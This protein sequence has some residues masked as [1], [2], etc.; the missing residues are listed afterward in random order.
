[1]Q[2]SKLGVS[3]L[4]VMVAMVA[5]AA[6]A[7][8]TAGT[9]WASLSDCIDATCRIT[10]ADGSC[11]TGCVFEIDQG[12]VYV[13]TAAHVVGND[14][15]VQCEFWRQG[16]QSAPLAGQV[17]SRS[18]EAD[19]AI[20]AVPE[21]ALG[22]L[23]PSVIPLAPRDT[24]IRPG[25]TLTSVGCANGAWSTSWKGHALE[26]E[27]GDL[28]F[29]PTPANGRSGSA[30]FDA[31]GQRIVGVLRARTGD[32]AE[33]IATPIQTIYRAFDVAPQSSKTAVPRSAMY[34]AKA[35]AEPV[36]RDAAA[37]PVA[38]DE[39]AA[40]LDMVPVQCGPGGCCP[41]Q[42]QQQP[43]PWQN[44]LLPYRSRHD[45]PKP[46]S[47]WPSLPPV[48]VKPAVDIS[49]LDEKLGRI[50]AMLEDMKKSDV[51]GAAQRAAATATPGTE[52]P[53]AAVDEPARKAAETALNQVAELR[54]E[55]ERNL[56]D[57]KTDVAKANEA[58][59]GLTTAVERI[60]ESMEE[61]G[62]LSQ[63]FHARVDK[64]KAELEEKLGHE[65]SNHEVRIAYLKDLIQD[66]LG[67]GGAMKMLLI[68][69]VLVLVVW[70]IA[71]DV[72]NK[73]EL[74]TPLAVERLVTLVESKFGALHDRVDALKDRL[75]STTA[76]PAAPA[77]P[78]A[79]PKTGP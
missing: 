48:V 16:H 22:G 33:G 8:G 29:L 47:P 76:A 68:P 55:S 40:R 72:K 46:S 11:G 73:V 39:W 38:R 41:Q 71:R 30:V 12:S 56:H 44:H 31:E 42:Q 21:T 15:A 23:L 7:L 37:E 6:F 52:P 45:T 62:T 27:D 75:Q 69:A 60:K 26:V 28:H 9:C 4:E 1:M 63:R 49:P 61:N 78:A 17:L 18:E 24:V 43:Q 54:N 14:P 70:L 53:K 34:A 19:A 3:C 10:T 5:G 59:G 25:D 51:A 77:A 36:A 32:G 58:V 67:D 35:L 2:R 57:V 79:A 64:V 65:A 50:A 74:G 66:K 20:V 13:L